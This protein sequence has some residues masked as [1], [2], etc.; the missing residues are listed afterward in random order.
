MSLVTNG[1]SLFSSQ[2]YVL[3]F[4]NTKD[5]EI[6]TYDTREPLKALR[7]IQSKQPHH[8]FLRVEG[9]PAENVVRDIVRVFRVARE[10][11]GK[12]IPAAEHCRVR[13][14]ELNATAAATAASPTTV[15]TP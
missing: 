10:A 9:Y 11:R 6:Y 15:S 5:G 13:V 4:I 12:L 7:D 14:E 3:Y 2:Y 1:Q 8:E